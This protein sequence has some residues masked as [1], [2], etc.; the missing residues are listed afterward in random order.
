MSLGGQ[1]YSRITIQP[2]TFN[3]RIPTDSRPF[4]RNHLRES[5]LE[6]R[7]NCICVT[8]S[9]RSRDLRRAL[10]VSGT[11]AAALAKFPRT[12]FWSLGDNDD[13]HQLRWPPSITR[14]WTTPSSQ[15]WST[16]PFPLRTGP[17]CLRTT[18][19]VRPF[20]WS[21]LWTMANRVFAQCSFAPVI[22][23]RFLLVL[24]LSSVTSSPTS[25]PVSSTST[26][27]PILPVTK[28]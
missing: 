3:K 16:P 5:R 19:S 7:V 25:A 12:N 6:S 13:N 21:N 1:L 26:S 20:S 8:I 28:S 14:R 22:S 4:S 17:F 10:T 18:T 2:K 23:L 15:R 27:P 11:R 9:P 24:L